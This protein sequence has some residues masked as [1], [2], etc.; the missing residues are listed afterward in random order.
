MRR[1]TTLA[2]LIMTVIAA[3]IAC[4]DDA[5]TREEASIALEEV[6]ASTQSQAL[7]MDVL[8]ISTNFTIGQAVEAS[9]QELKAFVESQIPCSTA[10][11]EDKTLTIDFGALGDNCVFKGRTYAGVVNIAMER[12]ESQE[13]E[14]THTWTD[15]T[16]GK[17][18]LNG[19]ASVI[20]SSAEGTRRVVHQVDWTHGDISATATGDRTQRL[21]DRGLG[22]AGGIEISGQRTWT[23]QRGKWT[24]D[25]DAVQVRGQDP[26]PQS[27][28]Y[29]LNN[30]EGKTLAMTFSRLDETTIEV[31]V[32]GTRK[33]FTFKVRSTAGQS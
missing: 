13:V 15:L 33:D 28:T 11:V 8:E 7:T 17:V 22:L 6:Q 32:S 5:L 21:I 23:S 20:W 29:T 24:L 10:T 16:D 14:V 9:L 25:I 19:G 26:V 1:E 4:K 27:G 31:K 12:T 3:V 30:P 2:I 18:T